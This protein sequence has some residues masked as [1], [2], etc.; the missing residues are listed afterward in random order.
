MNTKP[1][2]KYFD[3]TNLK[4]TATKEDIITLCNEA[5]EYDFC[6]VCVNQYYVQLAYEQLQDTDIKVAAV[7]GFPLGAS[8]LETKFYET[9][10][11]CKNGA[12]E[13]DMVIN[14]GALK[15]GDYETVQNEI[16]AIVASADDFEATVKVILETCY[17]TDDEIVKACELAVAAGAE[18]VK[19]STGFGPGG[20]T[21][22][23]IAL[24]R[25]SVGNLAQIKASGGIRDY[26]T[27]MKMIAAGADRIGASASVE[28]MKCV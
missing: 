23:H 4:P 18:F 21:E 13:I 24:M 7:V 5:K 20:A 26:D 27:A 17:L 28:I 8:G 19:T 11:C 2:N 12:S 25:K 16:A 10:N 14:I 6:S 9:V 15:D 22:H 1:L 3:H